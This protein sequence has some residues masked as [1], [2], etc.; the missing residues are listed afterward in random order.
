MSAA[1]TIIAYCP[2]S[3]GPKYLAKMMAEMDE[4]K[5]ENPLEKKI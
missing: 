5:I 3:S 4:A 2:L 1:A